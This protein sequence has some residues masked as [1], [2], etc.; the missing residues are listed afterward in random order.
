MGL[1]DKVIDD[2]TLKKSVHT[3]HKYILKHEKDIN[4][5]FNLVYTDLKNI[6]KEVEIIND[7]MV[8]ILKDSSDI[9]QELRVVNGAVH[10]H[11]TDILPDI[12]FDVLVVNS[13]SNKIYI[14]KRQKEVV[15]E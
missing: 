7:K 9:N 15:P 2:N 11:T 14:K 8:I 6:F 4:E 12:S 13:V 5:I 3:M 1:L 10:K